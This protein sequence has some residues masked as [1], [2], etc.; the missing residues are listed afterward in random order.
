MATSKI[1]GG[2][3]NPTNV[4]PTP[5]RTLTAEELTAFGN[6]LP[7]GDN[8]A[9]AS[10][11]GKR[12]LANTTQMFV[13]NPNIKSKE[14]VTNSQSDWKPA[15][16]QEILIRARK[17]G[18]KDTATFLANKE[19]LSNLSNPAYKDALKNPEFQK[20]HPNWWGVISDLYKERL[21]NQ[22]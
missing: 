19:Y 12:G 2:V 15:A 18:I 22:K 9:Y 4:V 1:F 3:P 21:A 8:K 6:W 10:D 11:L 13:D 5:P 17:A 20:I 14:S 16:I 7:N